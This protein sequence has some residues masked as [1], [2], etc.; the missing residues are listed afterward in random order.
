MKNKINRS[1]KFLTVDKLY[2]GLSVFLILA[3]FVTIA[4]SGGKNFEYLF[5]HGKTLGFYPDLFESV[6]HARTRNP[7]ELDA[8]Y[9]AFAYCLI[10]FFNFFIPGKYTDNFD[11]LQK[12]CD[13]PESLVIAHIFYTV[14]T[15]AIV[16]FIIRTFGEEK[17]IGKY[18]TVFIFITSSPFIFLIERGN[19]VI[20]TIAF[21]FVYL[22]YY[23]SENKKLR[24]L[25]LIC[26]A[27]AAAMKIYPAVF[28]LL[29]LADKKYK[30][31]F[32]AVIYGIVL[33]V[34]PF[35]F[36]GGIGE[37]PTMLKNSLTLN[38]D[39]LSGSTGFGYG[40]KVNATSSLGCLLN[41]MFGKTYTVYIKMAVYF[42]M[43]LLLFS[44]LFIKKNWKR[45]AA[46][47][48]VVILMPDFSFIYNVI[49]L[50]PALCMFIKENRGK[51]LTFSNL[52]YTLC[53]VG[54]FAPLPY[55]D[56]FRSIGGYNNMNWGTLISSLSLMLLAFLI[57]AEGVVVCFKGK[58]KAI[59]AGVVA[60]SL[61]VGCVPYVISKQSDPEILQNEDV[62]AIT[63][64]EKLQIED[65]KEFVQSDLEE[66][67]SVLCFPTVQ[68]LD[69]FGEMDETFYYSSI[70]RTNTVTQSRLFAKIQP[71]FVIADLTSYEQYQSQVEDEDL[72]AEENE[73]QGR[74]IAQDDYEA[75]FSMQKEVIDFLN[76]EDYSVVKYVKTENNRYIAVW[77]YD[78]YAE[79]TDFWN[80]GGTGKK[81]DPYKISNYDQLKAFSDVSNCGKNFSK[82]YIVLTNDIDAS[83]SEVFTPIAKHNVIC[84]FEGVFDGQGYT[85]SNLNM[86]YDYKKENDD[87]SNVAFVNHLEGAVINLCISDS[88][89][90]GTSASV[91]VRV[92][93]T[94][95]ALIANCLSKNNT[96]TA[97]RRGSSIADKYGAEIVNCVATGNIVSGKTNYGFMGIKNSGASV[98]SSFTSDKDSS[99]YAN[100]LSEDILN[101]QNV[102]DSLNQSMT[103][104]VLSQE[105]SNKKI[106]KKSKKVVI[107]DY[108]KWVVSDNQLSLSA[109]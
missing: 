29:L 39:T 13:N 92:S 87:Y 51:K 77:E 68:S 74:T 9:P 31:A 98:M 30:E 10:Y 93:D 104:F 79:N 70:E 63:E 65:I 20:I 32:R 78:K 46:L 83:S 25:A 106:K 34:V 27:C 91:F 94:E 56:I 109:E 38:S 23:N 5:W 21:L 55:G 11:D 15:L 84:A 73:A 81:D 14:I 88:R 19:T 103:N 107:Y 101:S 26:L 42:V 43:A 2:F 108:C 37:I 102:A 90:N 53:F 96:V 22:L 44:S 80:N 97:I 33:F 24:E 41:W 3:A 48:L 100:L 4:V 89:F 16:Y 59:I 50:L 52:V 86:N 28:G 95:K 6:I 105:E 99:N 61:V 64:E 57:A 82:E 18:L 12:I 71:Q 60:A 17:Y 54:A 1:S 8:I 85:I 47:A 45:V 58:K 69:T 40:F 67:E 66:G 35:F 36:M 62:W 7:Y 72:T 76:D 49:Y 75:L